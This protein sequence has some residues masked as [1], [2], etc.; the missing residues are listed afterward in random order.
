MFFC[1]LLASVISKSFTN[2]IFIPLYVI[3]LFFFLLSRLPFIL[4]FNSF[5]TMSLVWPPLYSSNL[6]GYSEIYI[7]HQVW[8]ILAHNFVK[9]IFFLFSS[10]F[11]PLSLYC[12][13]HVLHH[14]LLFNLSLGLCSFFSI[15]FLSIL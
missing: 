15:V 13:I 11:S 3:C 9:Y 4:V 1:S 6:G 8:E 2:C 5:T 10:L 14:L 7:I 12:I